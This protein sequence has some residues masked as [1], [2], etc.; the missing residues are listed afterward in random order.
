MIASVNSALQRARATIEAR[1]KERFD[2][3]QA[4]HQARIEARE[5]KIEATGK[6]PGGK[7]PHRPNDISSNGSTYVSCGSGGS[8]CAMAG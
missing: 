4:E 2:R 5:A 8:A 7:P 1:A 3:E 6:R